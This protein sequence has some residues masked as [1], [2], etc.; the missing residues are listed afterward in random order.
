MTMKTWQTAGEFTEIAYHKGLQDGPAEGVAKITITRPERRNA[1]TPQTVTEMR[2]ALDEARE[3][4]E[5]GVIILTGEGDLAFC[6]GGD[7]KIRAERYR[8]HRGVD[9]HC[10]PRQTSGRG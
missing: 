1:F 10:D 9:T 6:S 2:I 5:I 4:Q 3:D 7:Q 8:R